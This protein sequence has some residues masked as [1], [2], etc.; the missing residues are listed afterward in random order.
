MDGFSSS[1]GFIP[2]ED[3]DVIVVGSGSASSTPAI[4]A[5]QAITGQAIRIDGGWSVSG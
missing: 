4:A 1:A 2:E 5:A 3:L